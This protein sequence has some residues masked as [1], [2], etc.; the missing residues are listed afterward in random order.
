MPSPTRGEGTITGTDFIFHGT[1][2]IGYPVFLSPAEM[3]LI[4]S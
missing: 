2:D 1:P 4:V 3:P